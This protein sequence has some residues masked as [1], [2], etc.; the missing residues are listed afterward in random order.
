MI[1]MSK[2]VTLS[3]FIKLLVKK[4][5]TVFFLFNYCCKSYFMGEM[6]NNTM[7]AMKRI[8]MSKL[9]NI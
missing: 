9:K 7:N 4:M 3:K 6:Y 2:K 5:L 1:A 8:T